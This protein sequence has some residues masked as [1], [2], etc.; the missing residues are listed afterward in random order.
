MQPYRDI[1]DEEWDRVVPLLPELKPRK[2]SRGRPLT[3]TRSVLNGVLWVLFS[4]A[5]WATLPRKYPSY[6]TC[7]RRFKAWHDRGVLKKIAEQLFGPSCDSF[8]TVIT[9]RMRRPAQ[10]PVVR[11]RAAPAPASPPAP[12]PAPAPAAGPAS[13]ATVAATSAV[14][15]PGPSGPIARGKQLGTTDNGVVRSANA[16]A[17][18]PSSVPKGRFVA[19]SPLTQSS[20]S[21]QSSQ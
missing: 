12:A 2:E 19:I 9:A 15:A 8:Y 7:H 6:Q 1:T 17:L 11:R 16:V 10:H 5:S 3:N 4:G 20:Q 14:I 21:S 18:M 13:A